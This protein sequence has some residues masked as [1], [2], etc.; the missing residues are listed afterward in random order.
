MHVVQAYRFALD[1][2]PAQERMLHS[3]AGAARF[4]WNLGLAR[5]NE[6][7]A[8][9]R[10]WYSAGELHKLWNA[11]KKTSPDL[12]WWTK[13]SK[14]AYQEAFRNLDRALRGYR[15]AKK[16]ERKGR[17]LGFP[18]FKKKGRCRDSFRFSTGAMRCS[19]ATVT[20]LRLATIRTHE[21][22][23]KLARRLENGT[24]RIL[25]ATVS[26]SAQRW[27][28]S[29]AVEI[30]RDIPDRHAHPGS[31][32]GIDLGVKT[33]LTEVDCDGNVITVEG[34]EPLRGTL[35]KLRRASRAHSRR[36][37]G[38]ANRRKAV[39]RLG[40]FHAR[41]ANIRAD[42]LHKATSALATRYETIVAEDLNTVTRRYSAWTAWCWRRRRRSV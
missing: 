5:C 21:S 12:A 26:R 31:A 7:Y 19:G 32:V 41:V 34:P 20:L 36:Q 38:S 6:R 2:S 18:R 37:K 35:R 29:F 27:Y 16:G 4:A 17:R 22:T 39:T 9:E 30:D 24:A 40:R 33:L 15:E 14:C 13:N 28:V 8:A 3:H 42:A 25:S 10:R 11:E 1:P 23:R